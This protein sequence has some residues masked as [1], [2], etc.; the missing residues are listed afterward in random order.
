M[1]TMVNSYHIYFLSI[2]SLRKNCIMEKEQTSCSICWPVGL[3]V[4]ESPP[5]LV[6]L[7]GLEFEPR[8]GND[9]E[10]CSASSLR[11]ASTDLTC[12]ILPLSYTSGTLCCSSLR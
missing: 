12:I 6:S 2:S 8:G 10:R 3:V 11:I 4:Q 1:K 7:V 9:V 5:Q